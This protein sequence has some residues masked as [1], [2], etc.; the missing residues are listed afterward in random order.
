MAVRLHLVWNCGCFALTA[1]TPSKKSLTGKYFY[2]ELLLVTD[3]SQPILSGDGSLTFDGNGG[4]AGGTYSVDSS[5]AVTMTDPLRNGKTI[6]ARG[7]T[8]VLIGF[9][10]E[11]GNNV[12]S[13]F[14]AVP[15]PALAIV[16]DGRGATGINVTIPVGVEPSAAVPLAIQTTNGFTDMADI[17]IQ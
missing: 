9:N 11:A 16:T 3:A 4:F 12:F 13:I 2:H 10:T 8:G 5:G 14:V 6:N 1:Q 7:G 15:A 17:A